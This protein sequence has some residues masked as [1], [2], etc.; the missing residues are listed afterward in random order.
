MESEAEFYIAAA[1]FRTGPCGAIGLEIERIIHD[2]AD[3]KRP[4]PVAEVRSV[5][6]DAG[7]SLPRGGVV[8]FEPG[9][10]LEVSTAC[11]PGFAALVKDVRTDLAAIDA[12]VTDAGLA[13]CPVALDGLRPPVRTLELP[14]YEAMEEYYGRS[15]P[16]GVTMM[17]STASLQ[18]CLDAGG[19]GTGTGSAVQRWRRLH[20]LAPVLIAAFAN[21]PFRFGVPSGWRSA[22]QG[23]WLSTDCSRAA[24]VPPSDDPRSAW[25]R[26]ALDA[27]VLCIPSVDGSWQAPR[28]LTMREWLRGGGPRPAT[29]GDVDYHLTTL[30][31]HVRPRGF[32]ELRV[33]DA[34]AGSDWEA[35]AAMTAA[36]VDDE[37]ASDLAADACAALGSLPSPVSSAAR[38]GL[39]DPVLAAAAL[40]CAEAALGALDRL[41]ADSETVSRTEE[42]VERYTNR[43]RS[44]ADDRVELWRRTGSY[45]DPTEDGLLP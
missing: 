4:V 40:A 45:F 20:D 36:L 1:C 39:T 13:F 21:S 16:A 14:R 35:V 6:G 12:R 18:V 19:D 38:D 25:A 41:G 37:R 44:P 7:Q 33:I 27:F 23:V 29:L 9:G 10:Q 17:C 28:G 2:A 22:R 42:F 5:V 32:L 26:Y 11:A 34:Q 30:F 31:P 43:G 3:P 8:T 24:P 15:S